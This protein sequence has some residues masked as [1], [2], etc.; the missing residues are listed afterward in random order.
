MVDG[1]GTGPGL[2]SIGPGGKD[3]GKDADKEVREPCEEAAGGVIGTRQSENQ[4]EK[5]IER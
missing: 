4:D 2:N 5:K 3:A 1:L